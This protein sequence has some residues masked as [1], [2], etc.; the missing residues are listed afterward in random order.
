MITE[1]NVASAIDAQ[2]AAYQLDLMK[3]VAITKFT[4]KKD[5]KKDSEHTETSANTDAAESKQSSTEG[6]EPA[7]METAPTSE[8]APAPDAAATVEPQANDT[9]SSTST[10]APATATTTTTTTTTTTDNQVSETV[11][12]TQPPDT[13]NVDS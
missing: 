12:P 5:K 9:D 7:A 1:Q 8:P 6:G 13:N 2:I 4:L 10:L 3:G 11:P